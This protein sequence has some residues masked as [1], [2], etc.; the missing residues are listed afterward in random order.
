MKVLIAN[1]GEIAVRLIKACKELEFHSTAIYSDE[2]AS[3]PHVRLADK[4]IALSDQG[5]RAYLDSHN[6]LRICREQGIEAVVPGYGFLS[7]NNEFVQLLQ[8]AKIVFVGPTSEAIRAFGLKHSARELAVRAKV[9]VVPGTGIISTTEEAFREA[10]RLGYPVMVKATAG[11]GGMGLQVCR[12]PSE[13]EGAIAMVRSRGEALF[14]DSGLFIEKYVEHGRHIEG[15][16]FGNGLGQVLWFGERECSVQRRH[17]KVLEESPSP[18]V[19]RR[20]ELR[21]KLKEASVALAASVSYKSVGTVEFLVDDETGDFYFLEMNTRLQV[22]HGVTELVYNVDLVQLMLLQAQAELSPSGGLTGPALERFVRTSGPSGHAIEVRVYAENPANGFRPAPGTL[23]N[24]EFPTGA[25]IRVDSWVESGTVITPSFDP[26]LAKMMVHAATRQDALNQ[27][28]KALSSTALCGPPTNLHFLQAIVAHKDIQ[29]GYTTTNL[30]ET[31]FSYE[32]SAIEFEDGGVYST[33]Q[34]LLGRK[35]YSCGVPVSGPMDNVSLRIANMLVGNDEQTE[36]LEITHAGPRFKVHGKV[37]LALCGAEFD[38]EIDRC[39]ASMWTTHI[40]GPGSIVTIG[41]RKG[42]GCRAYLAILGGFPDVGRYLGS[43]STTPSLNWGG[44]QGRTI[45]AGDYLRLDSPSPNRLANA[46]TYTLPAEHRPKFDQVYTINTLPGPYDSEEFLAPAGR[47][48]FYE[49]VWKVAFNSTRTGIRLEGPPPQWSRG[50]GGEGGSHPSNMLGYGYPIGGLSFTGDS[51]VVF[52]SD[53]PGQSGFICIQTVITSQLWKLGQ[54]APGDEVKFSPCSWKDALAYERRLE[55]C[56]NAVRQSLQNTCTNTPAQTKPNS[57]HAE[58]ETTVSRI[59]TVTIPRSLGTSVLYERSESNT[60]TEGAAAAVGLPRF[61][62]R[63]GGDRGLLCD[64][65]RQVFDLNFRARAQR[66]LLDIRDRTPRGF[67]KSSRPHTNGVLILFDPAVIDQREAV[68]TLINLEASIEDIRKLAVPSRI[69]RLPFVFDARECAESTERYMKTQRPYATYLPD[70]IDFIRRNNALAT[71]QDVFKSVAGVP[72]LI[73]TCGGLMGLPILIQIDPRLRLVVPKANPSR[74]TTP[75]GAL[76]TGGN[77][78]AIYPVESPGGYLL[79]GITIPGVPFDTFGRKPGYTT[80]KPWL[81]EAF[82]RVIFESVTRAEFDDITR[83][84]QAGLYTISV[85]DGT[86]DLGEYNDLVEK[87][88]DTV[89]ELRERQR[90][91]AAVELK[92]ENELLQRWA[93]EK[94]A[95]RVRLAAEKSTKAVK[96]DDPSL[97]KV[98]ATMNARVWK[99]VA[100]VGTEVESGSPVLILEAM[101]MEITV[102]AP[103]QCASYEVVELTVREGEMVNAGDVLAVVRPTKERN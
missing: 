50:D 44:F 100:E 8:D 24:V 42:P 37:I 82:D 84:F 79:W 94:E 26:L 71:R 83:R 18:F 98:I 102:A 7:E 49:T 65:G 101:K 89:A 19:V 1:R 30:L 97:K 61:V 85:E 36:G 91:C 70:N 87:T 77:T 93:A 45:R 74:T 78:S 23:T 17:Q 60:N 90:H 62:I 88:R 54:L 92:K 20:P 64:Y 2:D 41:S 73:L 12:S 86:F 4:A 3:A 76:G 27:M 72:F 39:P 25:G 95:D 67:I 47:Q 51:A 31:R 81:F 22:E 59:T 75:A 99:V 33:V 46:S 28:S 56:L 103:A 6:I 48:D 32:Q 55:A 68:A 53:A 13:L 35:G 11:G 16:I 40:V 5:S 43:K 96:H 58:G 21:E 38:F 10:D 69:F 14:K 80:E 15:Q 52:A 34:D 9:P 66:L 29:S 63:Q 57:N